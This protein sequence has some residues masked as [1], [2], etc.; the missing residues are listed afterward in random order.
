[1]ALIHIP[2]RFPGI[3]GVRCAFLVRP[4]GNISLETAASPEEAAETRERRRSLAGD[5]GLENFAE[6]RQVHGTDMVFD[7]AAQSPD[8]P[9]SFEAD[10]MATDRAGM[11]L[12]IKTADCQPILLA[13]DAGRHIAALHAGWRGNRLDYPGLAVARF[14]E[15]YSLRPDR[16]CA[17]RGPSLGPAAAEFVR[18]EEEWGEKFR[19]W[20]DE[21]RRTMNL[22]RL[23]R[24]QLTAAGL[25]PDRIYGLDLCTW[26]LPEMF[27]SYRRFRN[28]GSET[29]GGSRFSNGRQGSL[30]WREQPRSFSERP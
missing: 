9:P 25:R 30:I 28:A 16:L 22:W 2:F 19:P 23:T 5:L 18:F 15:R 11:A 6:V 27:F 29:G 7:P 12:L 13:D 17:V 4:A 3:E 20:F 1:M 10:G 26:S 21:A 14:C 24:D 8:D